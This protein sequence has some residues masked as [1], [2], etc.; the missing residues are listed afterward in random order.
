MAKKTMDKG[1]HADAKAGAGRFRWTTPRLAAFSDAAVE[2]M[3][4]SIRS[5]MSRFGAADLSCGCLWGSSPGTRRE[6]GA[7][8]LDVHDPTGQ[9][10]RVPAYRSTRSGSSTDA[11]YC[12]VASC[13]AN[14]GKTKNTTIRIATITSTLCLL[15]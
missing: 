10:L 11:A 5:R 13:H 14:T 15:A 2:L 3:L 7:L 12:T 8:R 4:V 1:A 6:H 9:V